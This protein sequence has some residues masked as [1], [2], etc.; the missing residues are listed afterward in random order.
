MNAGSMI[1]AMLDEQ[2]MRKMGRLA[3]LL[4]FTYVMMFIYSL[5]LIGFPFCT[6]FYSKDVILELAYIKYI[7]SGNFAF[8]FGKCLCLFY[9]LLFFSFT[10]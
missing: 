4:P 1:H 2:N 5:Y 9:F 10:F 7:I 6:R 8:W 3:S